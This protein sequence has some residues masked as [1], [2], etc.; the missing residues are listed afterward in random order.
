M[1][2]AKWEAQKHF[3]QFLKD[4]A[5]QYYM[6]LDFRTYYFKC[7]KIQTRVKLIGNARQ[8]RVRALSKFFEREKGFMTQYYILKAKKNKKLKAKS[9]ELAKIKEEN[10]DLILYCYYY[11]VMVSMNYK[12]AIIKCAREQIKKEKRSAIYLDMLTDE[13]HT[14]LVKLEKNIKLA[15]GFLLKGTK[16]AAPVG[17]EDE[18]DIY[19]AKHSPKK[20]PGER[21]AKKENQ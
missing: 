10:K 17:G 12:T 20:N 8:I 9:N 13:E 16:D 14:N 6:K 3:L 4:T 11:N 2:C 1:A 5:D 7:V 19:D 15:N 18:I 21:S